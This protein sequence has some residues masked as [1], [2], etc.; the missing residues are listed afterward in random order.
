[1][2][3]VEVANNDNRAALPGVLY[4]SVHVA[5]CKSAVTVVKL[6]TR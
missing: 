5:K 2:Q 1:M 3:A 4:G 6:F